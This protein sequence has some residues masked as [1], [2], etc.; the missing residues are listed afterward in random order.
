MSGGRLIFFQEKGCALGSF[1]EENDGWLLAPRFS[2]RG[3]A[4]INVLVG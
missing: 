3:V 2:L 1:K 4:P